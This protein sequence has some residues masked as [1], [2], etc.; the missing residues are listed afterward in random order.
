VILNSVLLKRKVSSTSNGCGRLWRQAPGISKERFIASLVQLAAQVLAQRV[1]PPWGTC[2]IIP[3]SGIR[4][5]SPA[6]CSMLSA[7][8]LFLLPADP[9]LLPPYALLSAPRSPGEALTRSVVR[10]SLHT[11]QTITIRVGDRKS[12]TFGEVV[13]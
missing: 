4:S 11:N 10:G 1:V 3:L 9:F 8:C 13:P 12:G 7:L 6:L 2:S 5:N